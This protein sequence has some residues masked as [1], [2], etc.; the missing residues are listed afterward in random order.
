MSQQTVCDKCGSVIDGDV[1]VLGIGGRKNKSG[2]EATVFTY[3]D[4]CSE[5]VEKA[6]EFL[7]GVKVRMD[8]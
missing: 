6:K 1:I 4:L 3:A 5:C 2:F 7:T 8:P